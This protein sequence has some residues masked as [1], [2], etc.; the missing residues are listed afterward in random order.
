MVGISV[1]GSYIRA[2]EQELSAW[3][4]TETQQDLVYPYFYRLV[5]ELYYPSRRMHWLPLL[6]TSRIAALVTFASLLVFV[7]LTFFS[8]G[9]LARWIVCSAYLALAGIEYATFFVAERHNFFS[10]L[11]RC[12]ADKLRDEL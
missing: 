11:R 12:L 5:R 3:G 7:G 2:I 6:V 1:R 4:R 10:D 8:V 9:G